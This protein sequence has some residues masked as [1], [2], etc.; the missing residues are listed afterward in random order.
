M[1]QS[2]PHVLRER[3]REIVGAAGGGGVRD[4]SSKVAGA[5][6][7]ENLVDLMWQLGWVDLMWPIGGDKSCHVATEVA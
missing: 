7:C 4:G 6:P 2:N 1:K 5:I 3:A